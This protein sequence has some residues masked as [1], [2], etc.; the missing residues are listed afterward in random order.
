MLLKKKLALVAAHV[1]TQL[2]HC[3]DWISDLGNYRNK[4]KICPVKRDIRPVI[5]R[6]E[7][8]C[9]SEAKEV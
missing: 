1:V 7:G 9:S 8:Q 2:H 4:Y 5:T 3:Y 6:G